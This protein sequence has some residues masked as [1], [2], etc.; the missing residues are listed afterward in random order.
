MTKTHGKR[1][2]W[3]SR[4]NYNGWVSHI[5]LVHNQTTWHNINVFQIIVSFV[6]WILLIKRKCMEN[7]M[8]KAIFSS[9][10]PP[11]VWQI[12]EDELRVGR[13]AR[14]VCLSAYLGRDREARDST[15]AVPR[16]A[17]GLFSPFFSHFSAWSLAFPLLPWGEDMAGAVASASRERSCWHASSSIRSQFIFGQG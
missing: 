9:L 2:T 17:L 13:G 8:S 16:L 6:S 5:F 10:C 15:T 7:A 12:A 1:Q 3:Y 11:L 14:V 4:L